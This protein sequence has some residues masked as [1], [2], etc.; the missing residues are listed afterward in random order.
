MPNV[1]N[2]VGISVVGSVLRIAQLQVKGHTLRLRHIRELHLVQDGKSYVKKA[3]SPPADSEEPEEDSINIFGIE[4][5]EGEPKVT[6]EEEDAPEQEPD[7]IDIAE[8]DPEDFETPET[9]EN[10]LSNVFTG[11]STKK[12]D[13]ALNIPVGESIFHVISNQDYS[14]VKH[15]EI[16]NVV[17]DKLYTFYGEAYSRVISSY[18][19]QENGSLLISSIEGAPQF[20]RVLDGAEDL[21]MGKLFIR[22]ILPEEIA[23]LGVIR[24]N[25]TIAEDELNAVIYVGDKTSRIIFLEGRS[26][27]TILPLVNEGRKSSNVFNTLFSKILLELDQENIPRLDRIFLANQKDINGHTFFASQFPDI[28]IISPEFAP[29]KLEIDESV[30]GNIER[31]TNSIA[32][33]WRI[34]GLDSECFPNLSLLPEY[35]RERQKVLKLE[36]YGIVLL[37][38]VALTPIIFNFQYQEKKHTIENLERSIALTSS[39]IEQLQPV[40]T[41]VDSMM[42]EYSVIEAQLNR[43]DT[44]SAGS[45]KWSRTLEV[46]SEGFAQITS[47]WLVDLHSTNDNF[48]LQGFS[49]YRN[50]IPRLASI[51]ADA[52]ILEITEQEFRGV[53]LYSFRLRVNQVAEDPQFFN[54]DMPDQE[55]GPEFPLEPVGE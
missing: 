19:V 47:S 26:I 41:V 35:V 6:E 3:V 1:K 14:S 7:L 44:L 54:P 25:H 10:L 53:T 31:Y 29:E 27:R 37:I 22:E 55:G 11:L 40:K 8:A 51:F 23:L 2:A 34:T 12:I 36:W 43:M 15:K 50:R 30:Q 20:L 38:L 46:I 45:M 9:N 39:Q 4:E 49:L 18:E 33:A 42:A 48:I 52:E 21:Y 17:E 32:I 13:C 16:A 28:D 5:E 24:A